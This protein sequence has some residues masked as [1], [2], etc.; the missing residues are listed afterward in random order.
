MLILG[1]KVIFA[2]RPTDPIEG[3]ERLALRMQG[4]TRS[5]GKASCTP[6]RLDLVHLVLLGDCWKAQHLPGLL[7][8]HMTNQIVLVQS[9][10]TMTIAPS[11][12]SLSRL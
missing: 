7:L 4:F 10:L 5:T 8:K 12:L 1:G 9:L 11:R 2:E 6:D 3:L